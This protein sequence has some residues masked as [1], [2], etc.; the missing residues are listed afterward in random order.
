MFSSVESSIVVV[1]VFDE[2]LCFRRRLNM[3]IRD[4]PTFPYR[5]VEPDASGIVN[6]DDVPM[7]AAERAF[8]LL[9]TSDE[10]QNSPLNFGSLTP[11]GR[12]LLPCLHA[13]V[14][15]AISH[16]D[17]VYTRTPAYADRDASNIIFRTFEH[18]T[19]RGNFAILMQARRRRR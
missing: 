5:L 12:T 15:I 19:Q 17:N 18:P 14:S 11:E 6:I 1:V 9:F 3:S 2:V 13:L 7:V 10:F 4:I 16:A 8:F